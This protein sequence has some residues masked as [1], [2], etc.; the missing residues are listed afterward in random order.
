MVWFHFLA[1]AV[2]Q[3]R[4]NVCPLIFE[5]FSIDVASEVFVHTEPH[6]RHAGMLIWKKLDYD[7]FLLIFGKAW[8]HSFGEHMK[9]MVWFNPH[10][11]LGT[12]KVSR[13][14]RICTALLIKL[15]T[16]YHAFILDQRH[17]RTLQF[18]KVLR[19]AHTSVLAPPKFHDELLTRHGLV[20]LLIYFVLMHFLFLTAPNRTLCATF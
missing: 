11:W 5:N 9:A 2:T 13:S 4:Y 8:P 7:W 1:K 17:G 15:M 10:H 6:A 18:I 14:C 20:R 19:H 3:M 16:K 12:K